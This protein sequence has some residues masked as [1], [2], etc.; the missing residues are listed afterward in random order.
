MMTTKEFARKYFCSLYSS[1]TNKNIPFATVVC[2]RFTQEQ[3]EIVVSKE[4]FQPRQLVE[5]SFHLTVPE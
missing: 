5:M 4:I 1:R 3:N 2:V